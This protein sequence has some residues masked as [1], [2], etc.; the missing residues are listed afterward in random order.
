MN[1]FKYFTKI[2]IVKHVK[3][4]WRVTVRVQCRQLGVKTTEVDARVA[5]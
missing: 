4:Q 5:T 2:D 3:A 1:V